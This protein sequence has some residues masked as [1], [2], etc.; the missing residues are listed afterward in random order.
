MVCFISTPD[1]ATLGDAL[2]LEVL[3]TH[4]E[5]QYY[6]GLLTLGGAEGPSGPLGLAM[7]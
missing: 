6:A 7:S 3:G 2:G 5:L 4:P 1:E